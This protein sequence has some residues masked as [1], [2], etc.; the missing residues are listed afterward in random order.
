MDSLE[1]DAVRIAMYETLYRRMCRVAD[2]IGA[3]FR[4]CDQFPTIRHEL[5]GNR[6]VRIGRIDQRGDI[7]RNGHGISP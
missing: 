2:G 5:K 6:V 7:G 4:D 3:L 1:Q